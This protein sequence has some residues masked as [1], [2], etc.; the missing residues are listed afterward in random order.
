MGCA[1][2]VEEQPHLKMSRKST[3]VRDLAAE[4]SLD[5]D[6]T[7]VALWDA[8][9]DAV[10][11][12]EDRIP[13][14]LVATAKRALNVPTTSEQLTVSYWLHLSGLSREA[15]DAK[16]DE[17]GMSISRSAR[18]VPRGSLR[19]LRRIFGG[20]VTVQDE[21][22]RPE[23]VPPLQ[24]EEIGSAPARRYLTSEEVCA[25]HGGL[26]EDFRTS[27]DPIS[28]EGL[29][30]PGLLSSAL[31]RPMTAL[32]TT[33]K[34]PT[35]EMAG[36][37]LLHSIV[38][39]HAFHNGNK[40]TALVSLL[41][42]LDEHGVVLTCSEDELFRFVLRVG[43]HSLVPMAAD[44]LPDREVMEIAQWVRSHSRQV[45]QG[46]RPLKWLRLKQRLR[47]FGCDWEPASGVGNR[48]NIW[49]DIQRHGRFRVKKER[50]QGQWAW[51][52]DGT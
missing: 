21:P 4:A 11:N 13:A 2:V 28:P 12:P 24:W 33:L 43:Q 7:L 25:I 48:L 50:L 44:Q 1:A 26:V 39:N 22:Q 40:R 14:R 32:G 34:Y 45:E 47:E 38:H 51:G 37:A 9:V 42:F 5:L 17:V 49:R 8:G 3:S 35:V 46:E 27:E 23:T 20:P 52:G 31:T 16:L 18:K 6:E 15:F 10:L 19:K 41:V 36:A 30:D 29:R